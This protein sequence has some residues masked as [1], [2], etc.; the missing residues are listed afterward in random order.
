MS[1]M[2]DLILSVDHAMNLM[3]IKTWYSTTWLDLTRSA[4]GVFYFDVGAGSCDKNYCE[5]SS[6]CAEEPAIVTGVDQI[7]FGE[8]LDLPTKNRQKSLISSTP[9]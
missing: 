2:G 5:S 6:V 1:S 9:R 4:D 7:L 3:N 8:V